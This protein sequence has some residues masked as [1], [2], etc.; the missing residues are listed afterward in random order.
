MSISQRPQYL[1][2]RQILNF[3][4]PTSL[5]SVACPGGV[6]GTRQLDHKHSRRFRAAYSI[7]IGGCNE[8]TE[9]GSVVTSDAA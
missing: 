6:V 9:Q 5:I 1:H 7:C 8:P 2:S 4:D 3:R